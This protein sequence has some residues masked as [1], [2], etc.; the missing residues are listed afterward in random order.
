MWRVNW[1]VETFAPGKID[2]IAKIIYTK[3]L[4]G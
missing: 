4:F 3:F 1:A 2:V